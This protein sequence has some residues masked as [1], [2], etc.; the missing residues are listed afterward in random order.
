MI[1]KTSKR[2]G[3]VDAF[4]SVSETVT[5]KFPKIFRELAIAIA[6]GLAGLFIVT[7]IKGH[8]FLDDQELGLQDRSYASRAN[9]RA[10]DVTPPFL[11]LNLTQRDQFRLGYPAVFP[12]SLLAKL[13]TMAAAGDARLIILDVD[14]GW[15]GDASGEA[16]L[17]AALASIAAR[18]KPVVLLVR[19]PFGRND[20]P[21][22]DTSPASRPDVLRSTTFDTLASLAPNLFWVSA[23]APIDGDGFTRRYRIAPRVCHEQ[24]SLTLLSVQ[25]AACMALSGPEELAVFRAAAAPGA[26][27]KADGTPR[28]A[29]E[30]DKVHCAGHEWLMGRDGA[31][32]DIAYRMSW[33][34]P[35]GIPRP[36]QT[37]KGHDIPVE[38][39]DLADA[40]DFA[41]RPDRVDAREQFT[42]RVV[43][44]GSSADLAGDQ[45]RTALGAMPGMMVIANAIRSG[46]ELGPN[47]RANLWLNLLSTIL[48]SAITYL[49]WAA[50]QRLTGLR[51]FILRQTAAPALGI[52]WMVLFTVVLP[53]NHVVGFLIPQFAVTL[54]L[55]MLEARAELLQ[56]RSIASI[57]NKAG[58]VAQ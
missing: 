25:L 37:V 3:L 47:I 44:I 33:E 38:E 5:R 45:H 22:F 1:Q 41:E 39:V 29:P 2:S 43:I 10:S 28:P 19:A 54:Y 53:T 46:I 52:F 20:G 18:K 7:L 51:A 12:R 31:E 42:G 48:I 34:L 36:Q 32:A 11:L 40:L 4:T 26:A 30:S 24:K 16:E 21:P 58:G 57:P 27:C 23:L 56:Q 35:A 14:L 8:T 50:V 17:Q 13:V 9:M 49:S 55:V 6:I 15:S